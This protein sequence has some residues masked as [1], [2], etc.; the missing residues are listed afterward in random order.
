MKSGRTTGTTLGRVNGVVVV[1]WMGGA[2]TNEISIIGDDG[3]FGLS[4]DSGSSVL[5]EDGEG[6]WNAGGLL[7]GKNTQ[8]HFSFVTPW[9]SI[10]QAEPKYQWHSTS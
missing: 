9:P 6:G 2:A 4:G 1:R 5:V 8:N 3:I 7:I 10:F